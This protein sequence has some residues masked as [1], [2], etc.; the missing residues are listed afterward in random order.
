VA[1]PLKSSLYFSEKLILFFEKRN[2]LFNLRKKVFDN[3]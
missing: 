1:T 2:R 3:A